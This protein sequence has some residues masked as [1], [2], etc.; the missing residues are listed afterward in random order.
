MRLTGSDSNLMVEKKIPAQ[1]S[2]LEVIHL[3]SCVLPGS[4]FHELVKKLPNQV[5]IK[6][7]SDSGVTIRAGEIKTSLSVLSN[8]EYPRLPELEEGNAFSINS[9]KFLSMIK[10][11]MFAVANDEHRPILTG[12]HLNFSEGKAQAVATNS[13]R[14]AMVKQDIDIET[15]STCTVPKT[16]LKQMLKLFGSKKQNVS[17]WI[18]DNYI[19]VQSL[20]TTITSKLLDGRYPKVTDLIPDSTKTV[21]S[22]D[23]LRLMEAVDR[24]GLFASEWRNHNVHLKLIEKEQLRI[25]SYSPQIGNIEEILGVEITSSDELIDVYVDSTFLLDALKVVP[26]E[27]VDIRFHGSMKPMVIQGDGN[28]NQVHLISPVRA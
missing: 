9:E 18:T 24:A 15:S 21:I 11:T 19:Q 8:D 5:H 27:K 26:G 10:E 6:K 14:L 28:E 1:K 22:I 13:Q 25:S 4:Y 17:I 7:E 3:G 12:V 2:V 23:R 20:G 16:A